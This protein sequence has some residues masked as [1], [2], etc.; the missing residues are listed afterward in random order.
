M[1][2]NAILQAQ[3]SPDLLKKLDEEDPEMPES[4]KLMV[5][6]RQELLLAALK[7]DGGLDRLKGMVARTG[8]ESRGVDTGVPS[9]LLPGA[10]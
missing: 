9:H 1:A 8:A 4:V 2:T 5:P 10:K 6:Q 7:K 3:C